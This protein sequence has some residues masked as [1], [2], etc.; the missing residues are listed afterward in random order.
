MDWNWNTTHC[1][2]WDDFILTCTRGA[3]RS[4]IKVSSIKPKCH[5]ALPRPEVAVKLPAQ[6]IDPWP[7]RHNTDQSSRWSSM[8]SV[9][10]ER[11]APSSITWCLRH[12]GVCSLDVRHGRRSPGSRKPHVLPWKTHR[13]E[14]QARR[15]S[16]TKA[17][18]AILDARARVYR[19]LLCINF[20]LSLG[21]ETPAR[22]RIHYPVLKSNSDN[23]SV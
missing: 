12:Q 10:H 23:L 21:S 4:R 20:R 1:R 11:L 9:S 16:T 2:M 22:C 13:C 18:A 5:V 15:R 3:K 19:F 8:D 14:A 17:D 6:W 7:A